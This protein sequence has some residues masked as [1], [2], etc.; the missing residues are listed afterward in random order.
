M[1]NLFSGNKKRLNESSEYIVRCNCNESSENFTIELKQL[2]KSIDGLKDLLTQNTNALNSIKTQLETSTEENSKIL[3]K[4][5][6]RIEET[7]NIVTRVQK[8][9]VFPYAEQLVLSSLRERI[10]LQIKD[11]QHDT[12]FIFNKTDKD[13]LQKNR[14]LVEIL[15]ERNYKID[16]Q[17]TSLS[18]N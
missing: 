10:S 18:Y 11:E 3:I 2:N 5:S 17:F 4:L 9:Q 15:K 12:E 1:G 7:N 16:D 6:N 13:L 8:A 14:G